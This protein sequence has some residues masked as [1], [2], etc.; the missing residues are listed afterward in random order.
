M[1][2][3]FG[4]LRLLDTFA[5]IGGFSLG[6]EAAGGFETVAFCEREPYCRRL[7][8]KRWPGVPCFPDVRKLT[9]EVLTIEGRT[10]VDIISGGFPCQDIS[11]AGHGQGLTGKRSGLFFELHRLIREIRPRYAILENVA[12]LRSR[13]LDTVL[14]ELAAIGYDAEWHCIPASALGARHRRDRVWIVAYPAMDGFEYVREPGARRGPAPWEAKPQEQAEQ[15]FGRELAPNRVR[16]GLPDANEL[17]RR[18]WWAREPLPWAGLAGAASVAD[19]ELY[20]RG[21]CAQQAGGEPGPQ[22][23]TRPAASLG[24][25]GANRLP[26]RA[27]WDAEPDVGR[28]VDGLS[29]GLDGRRRLKQR[30]AALGNAIVPQIAHR[31]GLVILEHERRLRAAEDPPHA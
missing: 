10:P 31:I 22:Q 9:A 27:A 13:G 30:I 1:G 28:V 20:R 24:A 8:A 29:L 21:L 2:G 14:G 6:L 16:D 4:R 3:G 17:R 15:H 5:G 19:A 11:Y 26:R 25:T 12:A 23:A 18:S 7:L